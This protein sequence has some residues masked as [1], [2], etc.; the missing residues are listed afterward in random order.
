MRIGFGYDVHQFSTDRPL[1][2]GGVTVPH[3]HGLMG[4]SDADVLT[5]AI[6]DALL[7]A[8]A[9]GNIGDFFPDTDP[10]YKNASSLV[11]LDHVI[12]VISDKGYIIGNIDSVLAA[13]APKLAPHIPDIRAS[14]AQQCQ[15]HI[16]QISVKAT[17][18]ETL[19]F[20]G[21]KEGISAY[22]IVL[23]QAQH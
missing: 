6:M 14:L 3:S 12:S 19:G 10:A 15:S 2:L 16:N 9:L 20:V 8:L 1:I 17:T 22:A 23:L 18:T 7:G 4:H 13:E 21:R 11:L 5:H